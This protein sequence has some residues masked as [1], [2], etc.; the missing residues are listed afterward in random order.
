VKIHFRLPKIRKNFLLENL[1]LHSLHPKIHNIHMQQRIQVSKVIH[2]PKCHTIPLHSN[3]PRYH[4]YVKTVKK[5]EHLQSH[6]IPASPSVS[7]NRQPTEYNYSVTTQ[8]HAV[9]P[10]SSSQTPSAE[11]STSPCSR[12]NHGNS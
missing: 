1:P 2:K 5:T 3:T 9:T 6:P 12:S 7:S 8:P 10:T 4:S 11:P